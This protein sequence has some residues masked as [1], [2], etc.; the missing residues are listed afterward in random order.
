MASVEYANNEMIAA[1]TR[2]AGRPLLRPVAAERTMISA[3]VASNGRP[4]IPPNRPN[5]QVA[6][7]RKEVRKATNQLNKLQNRPNAAIGTFV[8]PIAGPRGKF[9]LVFRQIHFL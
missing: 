8:N 9:L 4:N 6:Q 7:P 2:M 3:Q 5:L 1:A